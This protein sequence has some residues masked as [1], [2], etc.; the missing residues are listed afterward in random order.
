MLKMVESL[1]KVS[2]DN[3]IFAV[4]MAMLIGFVA[5]ILFLGGMDY[6]GVDIAERAE[7]RASIVERI[8]L[9]EDIR[10]S[11]EE[12]A[13]HWAACAAEMRELEEQGNRFAP[14][15]V[16]EF[17]LFERRAAELSEKAESCRDKLG[18]ALWVYDLTH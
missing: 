10:A 14:Q 17:E 18:R 8:D 12:E 1:K 9:A 4:L 2:L 16:A 7:S 11:K 6:L 5:Y 15:A 3:V 13:S